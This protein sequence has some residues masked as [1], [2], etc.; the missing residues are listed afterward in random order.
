MHSVLWLIGYYEIGVPVEMAASFVSVC[1][2]LDV[3]YCDEGIDRVKSCRR[4]LISARLCP[5]V[6]R[7]CER[8]GVEATVHSKHGAPVLLLRLFK[9]PGIALGLIVFAILAALSGRVLWKIEVV[10]N[11][12]LGYAEVTSML[13]ECGVSVGAVKSS[14]DVDKITNRILINTDKISWMSINIVGNV[15]TV[16]IREALP[17]PATEPPACSNVV[18]LENGIVTSFD[19]VRGNLCVGIGDAVS[20]GDLLIGGVYGAENEAT[21]FVRASGS[22]FAKVCR[23]FEI[24]I[25]L[26]YPQKVY[27][28]R[29]KIKK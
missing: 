28:G 14:L 10:G 25:P 4:F 24:N 26:K 9:R 22:V 27:T 18:A 23:E 5:R 13:A 8:E 15:A 1:A 29:Q 7:T 6:L 16:E 11:D 17:P 2:A 3:D 19:N 21:R 12:T 20:K